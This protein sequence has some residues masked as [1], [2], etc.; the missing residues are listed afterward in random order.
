M[1]PSQSAIA[2]FVAGLVGLTLYAGPTLADRPSHSGPDPAFQPSEDQKA[3]HILKRQIA[4]EELALALQLSDEQSAAI[5]ALITEVQTEKDSRREA[6]RSAAPQARA[7]L[8][9]YLD[10]LRSSG[11]ASEA[12]VAD[13]KSIR[14]SVRPDRAQAGEMR[15]DIKERLREMLSEEQVQ[16][17]RSFRPMAGVRPESGG[18]AHRERGELRA[19]SRTEEGVAGEQGRERRHKRVQ[20]RKMRRTVRSTLLSPEMLEVLSR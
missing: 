7:V 4:A 18:K 3:V 9:D 16:A 8:E 2:L 17:L 11:A 12:T 13:L 5:R 20:R 1:T 15:K 6:R 19:R 10:E 14:G